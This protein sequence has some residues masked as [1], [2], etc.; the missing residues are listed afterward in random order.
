LSPIKPTHAVVDAINNKMDDIALAISALSLGGL[1]Q[2]TPVTLSLTANV[3]YVLKATSGY[4]LAFGA[5]VSPYTA[6][7]N[8]GAIVWEGDYMSALPFYCDTDITLICPV[9]NDHVS[10]VYL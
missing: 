9:N 6:I 1:V 2:A 4:V 5:G 7:K 3:P 10:I 8:D